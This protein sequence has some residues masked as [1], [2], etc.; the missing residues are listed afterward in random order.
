MLYAQS[1]P[2]NE[3]P[4]GAV[5]AAFSEFRLHD[6]QAVLALRA[7]VRALFYGERLEK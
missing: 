5:F 7:V 4:F 1:K 3:P 2:V 6:T